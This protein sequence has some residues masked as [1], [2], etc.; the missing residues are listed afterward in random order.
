LASVTVAHP[1]KRIEMVNREAIRVFIAIVFSEL[2]VEQL[3]LK[4][5]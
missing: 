5:Y 4:V 2:S 3:V 1:V